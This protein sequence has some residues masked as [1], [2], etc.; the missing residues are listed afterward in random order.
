MH[1]VHLTV[2][3][4]LRERLRAESERTGAPVTEI[5]RRAAREYLDK[6]ERKPRSKELVTTQR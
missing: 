2:P 4:D 5:M 1:L 6:R 3:D